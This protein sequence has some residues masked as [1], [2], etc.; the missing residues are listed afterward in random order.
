M[1]R[2]GPDRQDELERAHEVRRDEPGVPAA[3]AVRLA[4]ELDIT[5]PEIA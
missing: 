3:L 4:Y 5:Q 2:L 1:R